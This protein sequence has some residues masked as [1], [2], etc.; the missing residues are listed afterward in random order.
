MDIFHLLQSF[1]GV[2]AEMLFKLCHANTDPIVF[3]TDSAEN[4]E[5]YTVVFVIHYCKE[6][7][8]L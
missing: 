3:R 7:L 4:A 2:G 8:V 6:Q 5:R 1:E